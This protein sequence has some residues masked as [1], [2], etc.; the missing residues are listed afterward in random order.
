M[1]PNLHDSLPP[2]LRDLKSQ[3]KQPSVPDGYFGGLEDNIMARI[4]AEEAFAEWRTPAPTARPTGWEH[5]R[6]VLFSPLWQLG[7]VATLVFALGVGYHY[8]SP[9]PDE[10]LALTSEEAAWYVE[11]NIDDFALTTIET[12]LGTSL[13]EADWATTPAFEESEEAL[14]EYLEEYMIDDLD[15]DLL[16]TYL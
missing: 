8:W 7:M 5:W 11:Q 16:E 1:K 10:S 9:A 13:S 2:Q 15:T 14:E 6:K 3:W 4:K 12:A